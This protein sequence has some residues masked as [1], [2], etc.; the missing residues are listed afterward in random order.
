MN[1]L[2]NDEFKQLLKN[3]ELSKKDFAELLGT[4]YQ[5]VNNWGT[6][7]R[8]YPYWVKSWLENYIKA[9]DM[10]KV[11]ETVKPYIK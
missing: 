1:Q 7:G 2:S 8:E 5:G 11:V 4:S 10:D 6:N 9:K 3:A